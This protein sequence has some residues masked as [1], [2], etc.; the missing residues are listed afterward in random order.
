MFST[1]TQ[2]SDVLITEQL[3][4]RPK[5]LANIPMELAALREINRYIAGGSAAPLE[6][7]CQYAVSMC[8][9]G[10]AGISILRTLDDG[11]YMCLDLVVGKAAS[12]TG[13]TA[14][15]HNSPC[16]I[17]IKHKA[18][19]L[20]DR[21]GRYFDWMASMEIPFIESL[22][23]P[24]FRSNTKPI[25]TMWIVSHDEGR[26]FDK[27]DVRI[28]RELSGYVLTAITRREDFAAKAN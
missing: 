24:I 13:G 14:P 2:L 9:A 3:Q 4:S 19:Q 7:L 5:R 11:E 26:R 12:M 18:P 10:S 16:G 27:E 15:R 21:P 25:G 28:L 22:V 20:F 17:C 6:E 23:I 1:S 8:H